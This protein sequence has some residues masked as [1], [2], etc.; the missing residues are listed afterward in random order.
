MFAD[1]NALGRRFRQVEDGI[2]SQRWYEIVGVVPDFPN[3]MMP[4]Q[5]EA[6]FYQAASAGAVYPAVLTIRFRDGATAEAGPRVRKITSVL[7]PSLQLLRMRTLESVNHQNQS[8]LKLV[9]LGIAIATVSVLLL[10]AAGI[11]ALMSLAVARRRR[12]IGIRAALGANP[13]RILASVFARATLQV[14]IGIGVGLI[15]FAALLKMSGGH[16]SE[17]LPVLAMVAAI[18]LTVGTL[19]SIGPARRGLR[20]QPTEALRHE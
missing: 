13:Q 2:P 4:E 9:G 17:L 5:V 15:A 20:I 6:R 3:A 10:S 7:D 1:G 19:A 11:Y 16:L 18:I 8:A 12:E 14:S